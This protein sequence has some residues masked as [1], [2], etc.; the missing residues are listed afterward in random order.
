MTPSDNVHQLPGAKALPENPLELAPSRPGFCGHEAVT[1][2]EHTRTVMCADPK[3]GAALDPFNFLLSNART[4]QRAW[5]AYRH[6]NQQ[7]NEMAE[8]VTVLKREEQRLRTQVK[9]L[10]QKV[11]VLNTRG[12]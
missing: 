1:L 4:I 3:C 7:A 10:Q 6:A 11:P 12:D 9:R 8:R 5:A 2:D